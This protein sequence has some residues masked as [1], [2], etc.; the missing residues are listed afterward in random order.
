MLT[1][2]EFIRRADAVFVQRYG[3]LFTEIDHPRDAGGLF[4]DKGGGSSKRGPAKKPKAKQTS[5]FDPGKKGEHRDQKLMFDDPGKPKPAADKAELDK[6]FAEF[7]A[8][9]RGRPESAGQAEQTKAL[10]EALDEAFSARIPAMNTLD[11]PASPENRLLHQTLKSK[12]LE[13]DKAGY[14][15]AD[16]VYWEMY[17]NARGYYQP[18]GFYDEFDKVMSKAIRDGELDVKNLSRSARKA[19]RP[20]KIRAKEQWAP[21]DE[22]TVVQEPSLRGQKALFAKRFAKMFDKRF[23][24]KYRWVTI[25]GDKSNPPGKKGGTPVN[26]GAGGEITKGPATLKGQDVDAIDRDKPKSGDS[27][28]PVTIA[29]KQMPN[30][31]WYANATVD[32]KDITRSAT[33]RDEALRLAEG[34]VKAAGGTPTQNDSPKPKNTAG[35]GFELKSDPAEKPNPNKAA[36]KRL[37][38]ASGPPESAPDPIIPHLPGASESLQRLRKGKKSGYVGATQ[39]DVKDMAADPKRFQYKISGIDPKTGVTKELGEVKQF[40]PVF[41]GQI[42]VWH[43]P[44]DGNTYVVNGHHRYELANRSPH[45]ED[46][47]G[48]MSVYYL[49]AA[50]AGE[51]RALGAMANIAEG[52]GTAIDAAKFM[53][54]TGS[55]V[56]ELAKQGISLKGRVAADG[57][58]LSGVSDRIFEKLTTGMMGES[59]ALAIGSALG[60]DHGKQNELLGLIDKAEN[61]Q[62]RTLTDSAVSEMAKEMALTPEVTEAGGGLFGDFF[63]RSLIAERGQL[64]AH[65]RRS[66]SSEARAFKEGASERRQETLES[67]GKNILDVAGNRERAQDAAVAVW[68]F[69]MRAN[70]KGDDIAAA[71]SD[72]SERLNRDPRA[73]QT[74]RRDLVKQV[75][76]I[77]A[78]EADAGAT[79]GDGGTP[80]EPSESG[81]VGEPGRGLE[82]RERS[83]AFSR[84]HLIDVINVW[85]NRQV[86]VQRCLSVANVRRTLCACVWRTR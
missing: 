60:D 26:I 53:R 84:R 30:G 45:S 28:K 19:G 51:A 4:T 21:V 31:R 13:R 65:L 66:L 56:H 8:K 11:V 57:A 72:A 3:A 23:A 22:F 6:K 44:E 27:G 18:D 82:H 54:D 48:E 85:F 52:R 17:P 38:D 37:F 71:I 58:V 36:Q 78:G 50:D 12:S 77:L 59:R 74:I 49:D 83:M 70:A 68:D 62:N 9:K 14:S 61:K 47:Q 15:T 2:A 35:D 43:D 64:K 16:A 75:R 7:V 33:S 79:D 86:T 81:S 40:N 63:T 76:G 46:W 55:D 32:G 1:R 24:D 41:G 73:V 20:L 29:L 34:D 39:L 69:D 5:L 25:G 80:E 42:L 67:T 10:T